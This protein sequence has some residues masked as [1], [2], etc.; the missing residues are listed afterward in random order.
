MMK[1]SISNH[2]A[3]LVTTMA[4]CSAS[5]Q[6]LVSVR[7]TDSIKSQGTGN[8]DLMKDVTASQL[9]QYRLDNDGFLVLG[10]DVNEAASGTEK[11]SSQAVAIKSVL[12]TVDFDDGS[13]LVLG[14]ANGCCF[15]ETLALLAEAPETD[16]QPYYTL[17]GETG[18]SRITSNGSV[19][20]DTF[21]ST[22]KIEISEVLHD[23]ADRSATGA[24][25]Q[26]VLLQTND[27][28]GDPEAFYDFSAGFED[29]ALLNAIDTTFIDDYS[30]GREEAPTV[31]LTNPPPVIDPLAVANWNY[32]P[33]STAFY[34]VGYEDLYPGKG[35]Y[36]FN[37]LTVA[38]RLQHGLNADG[39]VVVVQGLAYLLTRGSSY[40]HD[41]HLSIDLPGGASGAISCISHPD[42]RNQALETPCA[43][44]S[45][46]HNGGTFD[47][48]VFTDTLVLFPDPAGS[49]FV[50][51]QKL[52]SE[53]WYLKFF[54]GPRADF[55]LDLETPVAMSSI[56]SAPFDPYLYVRDTNRVVKL[57]EV[58][59]S[60]QDSNG[61]PFGMLLT[62]SWKPPLEFTDT[63]IAYPFFDDFVSSEGAS[64]N[65]WYN[66][67]L[68]DFIVDMPGPTVWSW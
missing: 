56:Q 52:Y 65:D 8:I 55:R 44:V 16:R 38:Y 15:S 41:W 18:S 26:I 33:S 39:D 10:V 63:G 20:Q 6:E 14:S 25:L 64:S 61:F 45:A 36:D 43:G 28:L 42:Y 29:L 30:A 54:N 37:D 48:A 50:N 9:E 58:D 17:L 46:T 60:Y 66:T 7:L 62:S 31:I 57:M 11:A 1:R 12:F 47:I 40:S 32:F 21:D 59:P 23:A 2:L 5:A 13:Q 35:D 68:P 19:V 34:L 53:P 3:A 22:L 49:L 51:S 27:L 67:P 24:T 4:C